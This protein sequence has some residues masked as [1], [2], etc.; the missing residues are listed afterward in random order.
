MPDLTTAQRWMLAPVI[1]LLFAVG[2]YPQLISA[3]L[4]GTVLQFIAQ[5]RY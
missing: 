3:T 1:L 4:P 5:V 2:M